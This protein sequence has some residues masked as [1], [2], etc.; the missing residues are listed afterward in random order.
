MLLIFSSARTSSEVSF[1]FLVPSPVERHGEISDLA[2]RIT[3]SKH[4][5][6]AVVSPGT[7]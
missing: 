2:S 5:Q 3:L 7:I 4:R 1:W 6:E